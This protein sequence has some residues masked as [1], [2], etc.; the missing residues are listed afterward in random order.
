MPAAGV[1]QYPWG[2]SG[3][4]GPALILAAP[5]APRHAPPAPAEMIASPKIWASSSISASSCA[6]PAT[7]ARCSSLSSAPMAA[8]PSRS[9]AWRTFLRRFL[10]RLAGSKPP[11]ARACQRSRSLAMESRRPTL[12]RCSSLSSAP[13]AWRAARSSTWR[14]F[15]AKAFTWRPTSAAAASGRS[16]AA[17]GSAPEAPSSSGALGAPSPRA[18]SAAPPST[19]SVRTAAALARRA[20]FF[21]ADLVVGWGPCASSG[22]A[23][24]TPAGCAVFH[25]S[26]YF[27]CSSS[28]T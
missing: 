11:A 14:S 17:P 16:M 24:T 22:S 7:L 21:L 15:L 28:G 5:R 19:P 2:G 3:S 25:L 12:A 20:A 6:L 9:S 8:L 23:P 1:L 27:S 10:A 18:G 4:P 13:S 26:W